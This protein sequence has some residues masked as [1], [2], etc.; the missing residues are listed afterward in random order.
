M[1]R[2]YAELVALLPDVDKQKRLVDA[3][4]DFMARGGVVSVDS[5]GRKPKVVTVRPVRLEDRRSRLEL[6]KKKNQPFLPGPIF[7]K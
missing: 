2:L 6:K 4:E 1:N 7:F 5:S 3:Y